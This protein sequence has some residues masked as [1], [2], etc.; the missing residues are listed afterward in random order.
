MPK[1]CILI[2]GHLQRAHLKQL[3]RFPWQVRICHAESILPAYI[4]VR[5]TESVKKLVYETFAWIK[6]I[7][8][9]DPAP[10]FWDDWSEE[11]DT[12]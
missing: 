9:Y 2:D 8:T 6:K 5:C 3:A 7:E 12:Q 1:Y 4:A 10:V 11:E